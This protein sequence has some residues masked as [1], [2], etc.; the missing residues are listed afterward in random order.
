[1][2]LLSA[3]NANLACSNQR[4]DPMAYR[5]RQ[6]D[7][8]LALD[9]GGPVGWQSYFRV[10]SPLLIK[11]SGSMCTHRRLPMARNGAVCI[12]SP[13]HPFPCL[14]SGVTESQ[15]TNQMQKLNFPIVLNRTDL[16][17][18]SSLCDFPSRLS[19]SH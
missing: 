5:H 15:R 2:A 9:V 7:S 4:S 19:L 3:P 14:C 10:S 6:N 8:T 11:C 12:A 16:Q 17:T 18:L 13:T 1:M